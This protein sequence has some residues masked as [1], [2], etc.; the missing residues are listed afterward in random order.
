MIRRQVTRWRVWELTAVR[1]WVN[2]LVDMRRVV[3][4]ITE[5]RGPCLLHCHS[6][7]MR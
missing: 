1:G 2:A 3:P 5:A 4:P 7:R 6:K